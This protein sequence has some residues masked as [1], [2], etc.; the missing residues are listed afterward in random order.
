M[1]ILGTKSGD[2]EDDHPDLKEYNLSDFVEPGRSIS[3]NFSIPITTGMR[4]LPKDQQTKFDNKTKKVLLNK[5][6]EFDVVR[7]RGAVEARTRWI[8]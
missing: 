6:N 1:R 2:V 5:L 7:N 4:R 3:D 8:K